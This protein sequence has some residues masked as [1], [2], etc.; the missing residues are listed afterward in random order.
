MADHHVWLSVVF[1]VWRIKVW[2]SS[3]VVVHVTGN[4]R[5]SCVTF[6]RL[7]C[8]SI[9][10]AMFVSC[11]IHHA[12]HQHVL[13]FV[14]DTAKAYVTVDDPQQQ[15]CPW[16]NL[17]SITS[18]TQWVLRLLVSRVFGTVWQLGGTVGQQYYVYNL[19]TIRWLVGRLTTLFSTKQVVSGTRSWVEI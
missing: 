5:P 9:S 1:I 14:Y 6:C 17:Y 10:L 3:S 8:S 4:G 16:L 15:L 11:A 12:I 19:T 7:Q 18:Q 13:S 2:Y